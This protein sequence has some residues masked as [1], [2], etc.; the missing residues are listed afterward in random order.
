MPGNQ[1]VLTPTI[2]NPS[3][4][5]PAVFKNPESKWNSPQKVNSLSS[6]NRRCQIKLNKPEEKDS[7]HNHFLKLLELLKATVEK[8][9]KLKVKHTPHHHTKPEFTAIAQLSTKAIQDDWFGHLH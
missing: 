1:W 5:L 3:S 9:I 4:Y 2:H 6:Q 8:L 7:S